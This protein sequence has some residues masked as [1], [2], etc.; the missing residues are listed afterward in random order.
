MFSPV[1][2]ILLSKNKADLD[3]RSLETIKEGIEKYKLTLGQRTSDIRNKEDYKII[4][5]DLLISA[6]EENDFVSKLLNF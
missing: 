5:Y 1:R 6:I 3:Q 4:D 2:S